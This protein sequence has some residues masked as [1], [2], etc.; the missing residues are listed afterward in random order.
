MKSSV[1][2]IPASSSAYILYDYGVQSHQA[3]CYQTLVAIVPEFSSEYEQV[4]L[5]LRIWHK[6]LQSKLF[7]PYSQ[8][9]T[10]LLV[11]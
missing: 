1:A 4:C 3:G 9:E 8:D 6:Q 11:F 10:H 2:L 7:V 5:I